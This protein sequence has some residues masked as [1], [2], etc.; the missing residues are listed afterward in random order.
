MAKTSWRTK[1]RRRWAKKA[2]WID[3]DGAFALLA[4]CRVLTVTLWTTRD[5]AER[6]KTLIDSGGCGGQCNRLLHKIVDLNEE[7]VKP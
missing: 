3:G 4:P 6:E 1:A 2:A 5:E 7:R